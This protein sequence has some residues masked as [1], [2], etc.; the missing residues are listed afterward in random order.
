MPFELPMNL[1]RQLVFQELHQQPHG[2]FT[3]SWPHLGQ[4][5]SRQKGTGRRQKTFVYAPQRPSVLRSA[6]CLLPSALTPKALEVVADPEREP[7][8]A[9]PVARAANPAVVRGL[10]GVHDVFV[11]AVEER[12][13]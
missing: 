8:L 4:N 3:T 2:V 1:G 13:P 9:E 11:V 7:H 12:A 5:P 6:F 10:V